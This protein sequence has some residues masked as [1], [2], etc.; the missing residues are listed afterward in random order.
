LFLHLLHQLA[1]QFVGGVLMSRHRSSAEN[2]CLDTNGTVDQIKTNCCTRLYTKQIM[3]KSQR[4]EDRSTFPA[5]LRVNALCH[6]RAKTASNSILFPA[7]GV[8]QATGSVA[9]AAGTFMVFPPSAMTP[10]SRIAPA[11]AQAY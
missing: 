7:R 11:L 8:Q 6:V 10:K 2:D 1:V 3:I 5:E 4:G 9:A